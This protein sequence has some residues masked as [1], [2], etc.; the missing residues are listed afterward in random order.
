MVS[1]GAILSDYPTTATTTIKLGNSVVNN[2]VIFFDGS[3]NN[4]DFFKKSSLLLHWWPTVVKQL[5]TAKPSSFWHI[6]AVWPVKDG[7]KLRRV[8][9][10]DLKLLKIDRQKAARSKVKAERETKRSEPYRHPDLFIDVKS[11]ERADEE[12]NSETG[13][14]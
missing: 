1:S 2:G 4:W 13:R 7:S 9:N 6:P 8:S 3:W 5:K 10:E 12:E 11:N 14:P